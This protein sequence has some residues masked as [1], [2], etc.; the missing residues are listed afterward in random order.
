MRHCLW[1]TFLCGT[2]GL[3]I[4]VSAATLAIPVAAEGKILP[5]PYLHYDMSVEDGRVI[6]VSE[7]GHDGTLINPETAEV[8]SDSTIADDYVLKFPGGD[9][10][11]NAYIQIP[12]G[13]LKDK[14]SITIT[15]VV[16]CAHLAANE[17]IFCFGP[18]TAKYVLLSCGEGGDQL[19]LE[20][21]IDGDDAKKTPIHDPNM[22][23]PKDGW[24]M[25]TSVFNGNAM[26]LYLNETLV[27]TKQSVCSLKDIVGDEACNYYIGKSV[28]GDPL[29]SGMIADF[30]IYDGELTSEQIG[31]LIDELGF[32]DLLE[33]ESI[34]PVTEY[35]GKGIKLPSVL[36]SGAPISWTSSS[37][38]IDLKNMTPDEF[39]S[40]YAWAAVTRPESGSEK[41]VLTAKAT[42]SGSE[43]TKDFEIE[44]EASE[45]L[46]EDPLYDG[47]ADPMLVYNRE[48]KQWWM[49]YTQRRATMVEGNETVEWV[50]GTNIG[51]AVSDDGANSFSYSAEYTK[52]LSETLNLE[53]YLDEYP[54]EGRDTLW[55]PEIVYNEGKYHMYVSYIAGV[56][57]VYSREAYIE[58][59]ESDDLLNWRHVKQLDLGSDRVIDSC[60]QKIGDKFAMWFKNEKHDGGQCT[61]VT[62]SDNL[63][64]WST[65]T[66][67][68]GPDPWHEGAN[69]FYWKDKYWMLV[70][71]DCIFA[72]VS[73]DGVNWVKDREDLYDPTHPEDHSY[74]FGKV[75]GA[76]HCDVVVQDGEAYML[77]FVHPNNTKKT[78]VK[79]ARLQIDENGHMFVD[80]EEKPEY[81]LHAP[82]VTYMA[83]KSYPHKQLY[84][85]G[86]VLDLTGMKFSVE[87]ADGMGDT[88]TA[89]DLE[90]YGITVDVADRPLTAEDTAVVLTS[91]NG[92]TISF[93]IRV[94]DENT[95]PPE[96]SGDSSTSD[97]S[98]QTSGSSSSGVSAEGGCGSALSVGACLS[99]IVLAAGAAIAVIR[100]GRKD[101][102]GR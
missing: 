50:H 91:K 32:N 86:E 20:S 66:L 38:R 94:E 92:A 48:K 45:A 89:A 23:A 15:A 78:E 65:P 56:P 47:A 52:K 13:L 64:D 87:F 83:L 10:S 35:T 14:T 37:E 102:T 22:K 16:N 9:P 79:M 67:A 18:D 41:I 82:E 63:Y 26:S 25:V 7:G 60:V 30:R 42:V 11:S 36:P 68:Y 100:R 3:G 71:E 6:D 98:G 84:Q 44:I 28:W 70:D 58:H 88:L 85:A 46:Y 1:K 51:V 39:D 69:V 101:E 17:Q 59:F 49:F 5:E 8:V 2:V 61:Y 80:P 54:S 55:A 95:K 29:F 43:K 90:E 31:S 33:F 97:G 27:G 40:D 53:K 62:Y 57:T 96:D 74:Q 24:A 19:K 81:V 93:E 4:S 72:L 21:K 76:N 75:V 77:Y 34:S 12:S 73:D 99:G